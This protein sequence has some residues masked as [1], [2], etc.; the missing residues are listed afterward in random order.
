VCLNI[1]TVINIKIVTNSIQ[2]AQSYKFTSHIAAFLSVVLITE[3]L[4]ICIQTSYDQNVQLILKS[5]LPVVYGTTLNDKFVITLQRVATVQTSTNWT[6]YPIVCIMIY[7]YIRKKWYLPFCWLLLE[8]MNKYLVFWIEQSCEQK[9]CVKII[10]MVGC[11]F[12]FSAEYNV[13]CCYTDL[14]CTCFRCCLYCTSDGSLLIEKNVRKFDSFL[15]H[16]QEYFF[17]N[18]ILSFC[19]IVY[20]YCD[21]TGVGIYLGEIWYGEL[22]SEF[23]NHSPC[24][25]SLSMKTIP[26]HIF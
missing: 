26:I 19:F 8:I 1:S 15:I 13:G 12:L 11:L 24:L 14:L 21:V 25:Y 10:I 6:T 16:I 5:Y 18:D 7:P 2:Q 23:K 9:I 17:C 4:E 20:M 22:P 3:I